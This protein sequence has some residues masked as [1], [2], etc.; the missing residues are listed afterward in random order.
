MDDDVAAERL[1]KKMERA[2]RRGEFD[3]SDPDNP[4]WDARKI[5]GGP[6]WSHAD[7]HDLQRLDVEADDGPGGYT[8]SHP[9]YLG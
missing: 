8:P 3:P 6:E 2:E 1:A 5:Y 4:H 9:G 7:E